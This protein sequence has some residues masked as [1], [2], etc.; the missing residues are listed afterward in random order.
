MTT[1]FSQT[2]SAPVAVRVAFV[3]WLGALAAGVA[4]ML[5]RWSETPLAGVG[6]RL[7]IY[8]ALAVVMFRMR[9]GRNWARWTL[10]LLL[11]IVG[12][13]S[14]VIEPISWLA[15]G[16]SIGS[17]I[18]GVTLTEFLTAVTRAAHLL[19]VFVAVPLMFVTTANAFYRRRIRSLAS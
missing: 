4:E 5:L 6:V 13:L 12:T 10:A 18:D 16:N 19:C 8:A 1:T 14:L 2:R 15:D 11:G 9:A 3:V 17:A 7:G